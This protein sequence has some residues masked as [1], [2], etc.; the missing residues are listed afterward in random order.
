MSRNSKPCVLI[1]RA[2]HQADGFI[3]ACQQLGFNTIHVPCVEIKPLSFSLSFEQIKANDLALFTSA[4]AVDLVNQH[5]PLPWPCLAT[6]IGDVTAAKLKQLG[7]SKI[8]TPTP[9]FTSEGFIARLKSKNINK[10]LV[11]KGKGGRTLIKQACTELG[12]ELTEK[13][14]Y[15]RTL[16]DVCVPEIL[17]QFLKH[18]PSIIC[19]TSDEV[20]QNLLK[21]VPTE[22]VPELKK[23]DLIVNS[24]RNVQLAK[25]LG[26]V[27]HVWVAEKPG[28]KGQLAK[29]QEAF[30]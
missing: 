18:P 29:L 22:L 27:G 12:I 9:P 19:T 1:T 28:D 6:G 5:A 20:L 2:A 4:N 17:D 7:Q 24:D 11:I 26:F 15:K 3:S 13:D 21:L 10:L 16:P 8:D 23:L 30:P 25:D 14:V